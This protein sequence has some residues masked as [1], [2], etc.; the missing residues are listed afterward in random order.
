MAWISAWKA[1][2]NSGQTSRQSQIKERTKIT[3][4]DAAAWVGD[5]KFEDEKCFFCR[6]KK[7]LRTSYLCVT[8]AIWFCPK[9]ADKVEKEKAYERT[10]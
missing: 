4:K 9:C 6:S 3:E 2:R 7:K 1:A 5:Y 8:G 10:L